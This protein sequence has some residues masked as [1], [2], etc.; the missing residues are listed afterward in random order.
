MHYPD[1]GVGGRRL[2]MAGRGPRITRWA[3]M[4][5]VLWRVR[6]VLNGGILLYEDG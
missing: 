5:H 2:D 4:S 1:G 6:Y 3:R